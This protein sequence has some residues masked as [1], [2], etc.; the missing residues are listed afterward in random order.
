MPGYLEIQRLM[1]QFATGGLSRRAFIARAMALGFTA[2]AATSF[3]AA[4]Q[5]DESGTPAAGAGEG[6]GIRGGTLIVALNSDLASLDL[7]FGTPTINRDVMGHVYEF[8]FTM[9]E[10]NIYIPHLAEDMQI[11]EDGTVFTITLRQGVPFHNGEEMTSADVVASLERWQRMTSRGASIL[12]NLETMTAI[13]DYTV[14]L[15]FLLPNGGFLYGIGH[16]GGLAGIMPKSVIDAHYN[17]DAE[18][19]DTQITDV[20]NAIGT[21][22]YVVTEWVTDRSVDMVR[23][24]NYAMRNEPPNGRGGARYAYADELQFVPVPDPTTRL[25][26]LIAGEYHIAYQ[27]EPAQYEQVQSDPGLIPYIIRPGSKPVAVFNKQKG[28]FT[29]QAL[30]QAALAATDPV[31]VMAGTVDHPDFYAT[32]ASLAGPEWEF[33]YTEVGK[34]LY[35]TRDVE[36]AIQLVEESGYDG[37]PLRWVTTRDYDYMYRSAL[38]A[39]QQWAEAGIN[40]ELTVTDWPSVLVARDDPD[41]YEVFSTGIGFGGDP[42]GTSAYTP[43]WPGW[44]TSPG[45][46]GAYEALVVETDQERRKEL[47]IELQRAFYEEVPYIQFGELYTLRATRTEAQGFP[48]SQD[49]RVWNV[50]LED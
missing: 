10:G 36:L 12:E 50:W 31:E 20:E 45:V 16:Y 25:N 4:A 8:L 11:S 18:E 24:E 38:V 7:M 2:S 35:E 44:T 5:S 1:Q 28:P 49:F 15:R 14:E 22:P 23:F 32:M 46:T 37:S 39:Q 48:D 30:R 6:E 3:M 13:D 43:D 21:G 19:P 40:V 29:S 26:G 27:L 9:G 42:L 47:W 34:E 41:A 17:P 33:W